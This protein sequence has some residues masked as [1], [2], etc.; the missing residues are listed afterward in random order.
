M[1]VDERDH[2][3]TRRSS[4]AWAK[5]T[6]A[7][8]RISLAWRNS[9]FSLPG[10]QLLGPVGRNACPLAVVNL[11]LLHPL[12]KRL[13]RATNLGCDRHDRRPSRRMLGLMI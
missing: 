6:D 5:Y 1:I 8:R 9:R 13:R 7:L 2:G 11:G 12:Q 3:F 4:S 10:L